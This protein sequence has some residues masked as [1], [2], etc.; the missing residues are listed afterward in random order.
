MAFFPPQGHDNSDLNFEVDILDSW[1]TFW[2][3]LTELVLSI[4]SAENQKGINNV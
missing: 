2:T 1:P 4:L 3:F